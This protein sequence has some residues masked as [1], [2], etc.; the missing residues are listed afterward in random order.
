MTVQVAARVESNIKETAAKVAAEFGLDLSTAIKIFVTR[1]AK[2]RRIP[3]DISKPIFSLNGDEFK[4][5][6]EYF[7]QI[8]E[9]WESIVAAS[10]EPLEGLTSAKECGWNV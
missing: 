9:Y 4:S 7:K 3:V 8:P 1:I 5:D 10:K 2:E 6:T